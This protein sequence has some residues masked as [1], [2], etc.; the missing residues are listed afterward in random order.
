[1][2]QTKIARKYRI[3]PTVLNKILNGQYKTIPITT[4][5]KVA[6]ILDLP[7]DDVLCAAPNS[8]KRRFFE[9]HE[10]NNG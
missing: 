8:L 2:K 4:A 9:L 3:D 1:M 5:T 6:R 10:W 7:V